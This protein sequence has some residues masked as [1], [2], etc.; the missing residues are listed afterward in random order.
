MDLSISIEAIFSETLKD[1]Y[2]NI[3][4]GCKLS[5][6]L[7]FFLLKGVWEVGKFFVVTYATPENPLNS[8]WFESIEIP[9]ASFPLN[10]KTM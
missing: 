2:P 8:S 10:L 1:F 7:G 6:A 4:R 9:S 3:P 5:K